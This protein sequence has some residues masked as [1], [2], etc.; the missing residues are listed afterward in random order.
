MVGA[1][2]S[3]IT[4]EDETNNNNSSQNAMD[5]KLGIHFEALLMRR[6]RRRSGLALHMLEDMPNVVV[7][8]PENPENDG[9]R[10]DR[11]ILSDPFN[12]GALIVH[13]SFENEIN[14]HGTPSALKEAIE[15][16]PNVTG[17]MN[18]VVDSGPEDG[19]RSR[20]HGLMNVYWPYQVPEIVLLQLNRWRS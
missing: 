11:M 1:S 3:R 17:L 15:E 5:D 16:M 14:Y 10:R 12:D 4:G 20:F 13:A 19:I 7:S 2:R 8:E 6:R 18:E 9:E